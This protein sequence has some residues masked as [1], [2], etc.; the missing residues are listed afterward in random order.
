M[1]SLLLLPPCKVHHAVYIV[2]RFIVCVCK[3]FICEH[4]AA[5]AAAASVSN[6]VE[7][8]LRT[9]SLCV[10]ISTQHYICIQ[11]SHQVYIYMHMRL[12][13]AD[14]QQ[15]FAHRGHTHKWAQYH[16]PRAHHLCAFV[17]TIYTAVSPHTTHIFARTRSQTCTRLS[18]THINVVQNRTHK[19]STTT[20]TVPDNAGLGD[21]PDTN[22]RPYAFAPKT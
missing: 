7:S 18:N 22:A 16:D 19:S 21:Q 2:V 17:L 4:D 13:N 12:H 1:V 8:V 3:E 10:S 14:R 11:Y 5:A 9:F 20:N 15:V 6:W